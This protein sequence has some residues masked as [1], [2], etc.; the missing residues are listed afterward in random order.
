MS[1]GDSRREE[2]LESI[3]KKNEN[4]REKLKKIE[5]ENKLYKKELKESSVI[6]RWKIGK[7]LHDNLAQQLTSAK[8]SISL[9]KEELASEDM[10]TACEE[11]K[12]II[13]E[14]IREVRDL[15]HDIIPMDV[16]KSGA[17]DAFEYLQKR[18]ERRH[19]VN[20][21]LEADKTLGKINRREVATNLYHIAEEAIKNA[22]VHGEAENIKIVLTERDEQLYLQIQDDGIG[23]DS[24]DLKKGRGI[25]IMK[26]R[27]EEMGGNLRIQ[28]SEENEFTTCVTCSLPL[29]ALKKD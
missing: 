1:Q 20:C 5:A 23:F 14:S 25:L 29:D 24:A 13:N 8:I 19:D 9:L 26:H 18:V 27:S 28:D 4:L 12:D 17:G 6:Q 3:K 2:K 22:I 21:K 15:S 16:E 7:Y 11:I 10:K